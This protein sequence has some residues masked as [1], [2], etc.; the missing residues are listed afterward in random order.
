[1]KRLVR[2]RTELQALGP[3]FVTFGVIAIGLSAVF[4]GDL[5]R[6]LIETAIGVVVWIAL[7]VWARHG[8][9]KKITAAA[10][11][12]VGAERESEKRSRSRVHKEMAA[13]ALILV[14]A[15]PAFDGDVAFPAVGYLVAAVV[16]RAHMQWLA[17][18]EIA[19]NVIVWRER[20]VFGRGA[21]R[22]FV[23]PR[24]SH[25]DTEGGPAMTAGALA[26]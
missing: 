10:V 25:G 11:P 3:F 13:S 1:M 22:F 16:W 18:T 12:P 26:H 21:P 9:R 7:G 6:S 14:L 24:S 8:E 23:E 2:R 4:S 17:E 20:R 5:R 15:F 19:G